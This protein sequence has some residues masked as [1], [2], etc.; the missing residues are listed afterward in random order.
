MHEIRLRGGLVLSG[1]RTD[2]SA[3]D[4]PVTKITGVNIAAHVLVLIVC[5]DYACTEC[6]NSS[7]LL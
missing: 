4:H 2:G 3:D 5:R 1:M 7:F 6:V